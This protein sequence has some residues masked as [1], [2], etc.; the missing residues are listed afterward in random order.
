MVL[1]NGSVK[2]QAVA[3]HV[4]IGDVAKAFSSTDIHVATDNHRGETRGRLFHHA[5]VE[6]QLQVEQRLRQTLA[7]LPAEYRDGRQHLTT[8]GIGRQAFALATSM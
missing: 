6:W 1:G 2:P 7:T 5:L 4:G 3:Y 8:D